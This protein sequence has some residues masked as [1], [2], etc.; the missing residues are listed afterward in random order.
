MKNLRGIIVAAVFFVLTLILRWAADQFGL[1][2]GMAYPFFSKTVVEFMGAAV[3]KYSFCVWQAIVAVFLVAVVVSL[4]CTILLRGN[5]LRWLGWVLAPASIAYFLF[6]AVWGLN[7]YTKPLSESMKITVSDY[8]VNEL[9]EATIFYRQQADKLSGTI[10][11]DENGDVVLPSLEEMSATAAQGYNNLVWS[12][13]VF[14]GP[15]GPVK[16]LGWS[17]LFSSFG[18]DGVTVGLTGEAAV[19]LEQ[20]GSRIPFTICHEMAHLCAIAREDEANFAGYLACEKSE[21]PLFRY[22][23]YLEAFLF[24]SDTLYDVSTTA[25]Q[26]AWAGASDELRHDVEQL[27]QV[28]ASREGPVKDQASA[29]YNDYLVANG[30]ENG[31]ASYAQ[32]TD[33]LVAWYQDQYVIDDTPE[34]TQFNPYSYEDVFGSTEPV[35]EATEEG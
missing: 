9:K 35:T 1:L 19:N 25:W 20:Y 18:T 17:S 2:V 3:G 27:N 28:A 32:V 6:T 15:R 12:Y 11:R 7:N 13:S 23:G 21:D 29:I 26:D 8:T 5:L 16:E 4:G 24:C 10:E 22:T 34:P 31:V 33:L 30:Q 14:A